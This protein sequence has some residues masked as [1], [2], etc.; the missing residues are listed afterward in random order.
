MRVVY[1]TPW[2]CAGQ[3]SLPLFH[4]YED[5]KKKAVRWLSGRVLG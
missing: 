1:D 5:Q 4:P 3:T 2:L